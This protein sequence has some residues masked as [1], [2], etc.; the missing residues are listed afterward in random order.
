MAD[1][2][3]NT[4]PGENPQ[5]SLF[6]ADP[7][8]APAQDAPTSEPPAPEKAPEQ[9]AVEPPA[10][11]APAGGPGEVNVSADQIEKLMAERGAAYEEAADVIIDTGELSM[12]QVVSKIVLEAKKRGIVS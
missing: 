11:D 8:D 7:A 6:E 10:Q 2:K 1:E 3:L 12:E 4:S 9:A 5:P